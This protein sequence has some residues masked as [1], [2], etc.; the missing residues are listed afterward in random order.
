MRAS[1]NTWLQLSKRKPCDVRVLFQRNASSVKSESVDVSK[2]TNRSSHGKARRRRS[3][4]TESIPSMKEFLHRQT[5]THQYRS[6]LKAVKL[7]PKGTEQAE[8]FREVKSTFRVCGRETDPI[9]IR[10]AVTDGQRKLAQV[11]SLVGYQPSNN[12]EDS[13]LN[14]KD[15]LDQRGRVGVQWPWERNID[16]TK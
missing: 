14:I 8:A 12:D 5:V 16:E 15:D 9:S 4:P 2:T 13:W 7:F 1:L 3:A 10:M 6:F 11:Q